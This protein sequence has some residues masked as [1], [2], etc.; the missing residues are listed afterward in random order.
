MDVSKIVVL[1]GKLNSDDIW[2]LG[3]AGS[4]IKSDSIWYKSVEIFQQTKAGNWENVINKIYKQ[5]EK[6]K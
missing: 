5:M 1:D 4:E 2:D 6:L 3:V